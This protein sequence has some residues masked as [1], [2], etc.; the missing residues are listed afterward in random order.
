MKTALVAADLSSAL[1]LAIVFIGYD[2]GTREIPDR[3]SII[4]P[5]CCPVWPD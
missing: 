5:A 4:T 3:S 1:F 2:S